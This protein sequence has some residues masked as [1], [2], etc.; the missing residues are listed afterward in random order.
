MD[1]FQIIIVRV[2]ICIADREKMGDQGSWSLVVL[3]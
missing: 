1:S 2:I 3:N